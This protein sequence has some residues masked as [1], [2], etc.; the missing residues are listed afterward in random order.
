MK[1]LAIETTTESCSVAL[2][3]NNSIQEI[4]LLAP[5]QHNKYIL[6]IINKLLI[7][8]NLSLLDLNLLAFSHGPGNFTGIR[9]GISVIQGLALKLNLPLISVSSLLTLAQGVFRKTGIN[10]IITAINAQMGELYWATYYKQNNGIWYSDNTEL[11][12]TPEMIKIKFKELSGNWAYAGNGWLMYP[13]LINDFKFLINGKTLFPS[14]KDV[15]ILALNKWLNNEIS[16]VEL[17]KPIYLRN[18]A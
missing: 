13:Y 6:T 5:R 17:I 14:A 3:N 16:S 2:M 4:F 18:F 12:L 1:I 7:K 9:I 15:L 11:I 10:K 8:N